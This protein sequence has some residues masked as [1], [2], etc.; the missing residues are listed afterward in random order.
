MSG[1]AILVVGLFSFEGDNSSSVGIYLI[2][3]GALIIILPILMSW[4]KSNKDKY[5]NRIKEIESGK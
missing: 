4:Y 1:I 3:G 2:I 5:L